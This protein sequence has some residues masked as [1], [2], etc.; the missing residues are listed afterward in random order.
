MRA[1]DEIIEVQ[2]AKPER[3]YV[4]VYKDFLNSPYLTTEE[5][6]VYI[7]LKSFVTYGH[8][9]GEVFPSVATLC[10]LTSMSRPRATRAITNLIKKGIITKKRRGLTKTNLYTI[11]D[12]PAMW[13]AES[14]EELHELATSNIPLSSQEMLEEL[15][16]RGEIKI[17]NIKKEPSS[18]TDQSTEEDTLSKHL[19]VIR[20]TSNSSTYGTDCQERYTIDQIKELYDYEVMVHDDPLIEADL[21]AVINILYDALNTTKDTIRVAGENKPTMVVIGK[22]MKLSYEEIKYAIRM[23]HQQSD[24][25]SHHASYMLTLLYKSAEQYHLDTVNQVEN[26]YGK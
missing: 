24:K 14:E 26:M 20:T 8:D 10:E 15:E 18:D 19:N 21:N 23:Y 17:L 9:S 5:K 13:T 3:G 12:N 25:V 6:M 16:R 2:L 11:I 7:A 1:S 22:L 4:K